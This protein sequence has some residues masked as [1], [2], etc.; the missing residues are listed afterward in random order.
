MKLETIYMHCKYLKQPDIKAVIVEHTKPNN[1]KKIFFIAAIAVA[2]FTMQACNTNSK[3][4]SV[5]NA[6]NA[7]DSTKTAVSD[8]SSDFMVKAADGGMMEVEL[9]KIAQTNGSSQRVKNF[10]KMIA[11]DHTK[12]SDELKSIA[13]KKNVTLPTTLG[14]DHQKMVDKLKSKKGVDFDKDYMDM[15]VS[16]HKNDIDEFEDAAKDSKDADLKAFATKILPILKMH[17][18]S[19]KAI[20]QVVK[21]MT[22]SA[23][24]NGTKKYPNH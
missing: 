18:D 9:G 22:T 12:A 7:N 16:D 2:S 19:A 14:E 10:G 15:M 5:D 20:N 1:M 4:D 6:E 24:T 11:T 13:M 3:T 23:I 21:P 17:L 8:N